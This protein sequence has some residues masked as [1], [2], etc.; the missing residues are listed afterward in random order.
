MPWFTFFEELPV[1]NKDICILVQETFFQNMGREDFIFDHPDD[2]FV[3]E[4][5]SAVAQER[6]FPDTVNALTA[7][8]F[9]SNHIYVYVCMAGGVCNDII[10]GFDWDSITDYTSFAANT[11]HNS[12]NAVFMSL[13]L[14]DIPN[15]TKHLFGSIQ[16]QL[17]GT[18]TDMRSYVLAV[19]NNGDLDSSLI[20][21]DGDFQ[22]KVYEGNSSWVN[23]SISA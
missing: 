20:D 13:G 8:R 12:S 5:V 9:R 17:G 19:N 18:W 10:R 4:L 21:N 23:K 14:W 6:N 16:Y 7:S 1:G 15:E 3:Q 22:I 2:P 11:G